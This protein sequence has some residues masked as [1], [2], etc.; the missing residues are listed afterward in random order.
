MK[1]TAHNLCWQSE[2]MKVYMGYMI[3][4][5]IIGIVYGTSKQLSVMY[6]GKEI[7]ANI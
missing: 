1:I 4:C 3:F 2:G 6:M 5:S 7:L